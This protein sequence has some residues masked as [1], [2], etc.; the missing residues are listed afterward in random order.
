VFSTGVYI[1]EDLQSA[2]CSYVGELKQAGESSEAVAK[3]AEKLVAEIGVS[4]PASSRT[5][6]LLADILAWC[7]AEYY[8][9][10]A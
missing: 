9:E 10:S 2:V 4:F 5:R 8:R 6:M 3:A 1:R 7:M